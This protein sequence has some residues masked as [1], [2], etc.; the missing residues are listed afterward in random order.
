MHVVKPK[1]WTLRAAQGPRWILGSETLWK[2][3]SRARFALHGIS[4]K[5]WFFIKFTNF[6]HHVADLDA[7]QTFY[8][9]FFRSSRFQNLNPHVFLWGWTKGN[10]KRLTGS[11]AQTKNVKFLNQK[12]RPKSWPNWRRHHRTV[13]LGNGIV[14]ENTVSTSHV[15]NENRLIP[16]STH[17]L[18]H[19]HHE[20]S[21]REQCTWWSRN[22]EHCAQRKDPGEF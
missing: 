21:P 12:N 19:Q 16:S 8:H 17:D 7:V 20:K 15:L 4:V 18:N 11:R 3:I 1:F 14:I 5:S 9:K 10:W 2:S 22:F 6:H 13:L